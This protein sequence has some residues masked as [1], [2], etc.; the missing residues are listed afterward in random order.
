MERKNG[1]KVVKSLDFILGPA[2]K[3]L[4]MRAVEPKKIVMREDLSISVGALE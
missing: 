1:S 3:A 4:G 2:A